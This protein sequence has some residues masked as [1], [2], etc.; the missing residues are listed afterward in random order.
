MSRRTCIITGASRG[1]GLATALRFARSGCNVVA[2]ARDVSALGQVAEQI[3]AAG[4]RCEIIAGDIG[5]SESA[6]QLIAAAVEHFGRVDI[7]VN[8]AGF[9]VL[10]PV[11]ETTPDDVENSLRVNVQAVFN[12]TKAVWPVM[13]QQKGGVIV[14]VSSVASV[15]PFPG[16]SVYGASKAWVNLFTLAT[17]NEGRDLGIRAMAVA[18]GAVETQMLREHVPDF[19]AEQTLD[20]DAVAAVIESFCCDDMAYVTGQTIFVRK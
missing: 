2:S 9:A 4:G 1:I 12:T 13:K 15:D 11:E 6:N 19:P 14:N 17:A 7:L 20:P 16:F 10:K 5:Q 18:P 8:N 3:K